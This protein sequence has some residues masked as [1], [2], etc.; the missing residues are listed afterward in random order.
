MVSPV[1]LDTD[2]GSDI[3]DSWALALLLRSPEVDIKLVSTTTGDT[4]YRA[5]LAHRLLAAAGRQDIPIAAG[6][7]YWDVPG[8]GLHLEKYLAHV[9]AED[10]RYLD[11]AES[12]VETVEACPGPVTLLAI[13]PLTNISDALRM[14][15]SI[16]SRIDFVGMFGSVYRGYD[17]ATGRCAE[18]NIWCDRQAA[19]HV[20]NKTTW[21]SMT[22]TP[23]DACGTVRLEGEELR[24]LRDSDDPVLQE[25]MESHRW[26]LA[27]TGTG[28][29]DPDESPW[30]RTS[31]LFDT[32]AAYM[33][34]SRDL[35]SM[36]KMRLSISGEKAMFMENESAPNEID[37]ALDWAV[38]DQFGAW[39]V[40]RLLGRAAE[41]VEAAGR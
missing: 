40:A 23:L 30:R 39:I 4:V 10:R 12:I 37:V 2:L 20:F 15:P 7:D 29:E 26:W 3:D 8:I 21:R 41:C 36:R 17:G 38:P 14:R 1:I 35:L 13:G 18:W 31:S 33:V 28:D 34:I 24:A 6:R 22:I 5:H 25:L 9:G 32:V 16:A 27:A 19:C 11:A